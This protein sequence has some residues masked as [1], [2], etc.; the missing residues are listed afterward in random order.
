MIV[1]PRPL[2]ALAAA[3]LS[4]AL[5]GCGASLQ[6]QTYQE[7][8]VADGTNAAVGAIAV[9]NVY[10]VPPESGEMYEAGSDAEVRLTLANDGPEDDRLVEVTS[11]AA[12]SVQLLEDGTEVG[13][14]DLPRLGTTGGL[15]SLRLEG[16]SEELRP[17]TY[18]ELT[19]RFERN[20]E[21]TI[22]APVATTGEYDADERERSKN[23]HPIGE[24]EGEEG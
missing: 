9:R 17:G 12:S 8:T 22:S 16:L 18:V 3:G 7:R 1:R 15:L 2:A 20:G 4:V 11:P 24:E 6:P 13:E 10:L 23:F 5:T 19:L 21:V 14:V